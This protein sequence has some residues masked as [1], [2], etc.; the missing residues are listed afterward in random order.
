MSDRLKAA[1]EAWEAAREKRS[2]QE[3]EEHVEPLLLEHVGEYFEV[4]IKAA[5][6]D[7]SQWVVIRLPT[8][9]EYAKL[10]FTMWD[11]KKAGAIEAK[12]KAGRQ[13]AECCRVWPSVEEYEKLVERY[14][15][16][17]EQCGEAAFKLARAGADADAK[18]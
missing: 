17:A 9:G 12:A 18:S 6:A 16:V 11:D 5:S 8:K 10:R 1:R 13:L 4:E 2:K 15:D 7:Y 3:W 14:P